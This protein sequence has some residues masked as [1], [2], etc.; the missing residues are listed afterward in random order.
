MS[1]E[2]LN[3]KP[4][5]LWKHFH[6]LTQIP[7]PTGLMEEVTKFVI[8]FGKSLGLDVKQDEIGNVLITK[9]A[10]VGLEKVPVVIL[11]SHLDMVPQKNSDVKHDFTKDPI[12]TQIEGNKV[13]ARSTTLGADNGIGA[14]AM[15][16]V[17]EDK[18][19]KHGKIEALF[20][21][22]EEVGM[23]GAIGLQPGFL[24]GDI[25]LN[26]DTE[27]IG[28]LC[29]GCA[30]GADV[31]ADWHFKDVEV[32]EGDFAYKVVLKGLRGGHSG[33]E[34]HLGRANANKL[35]FYFLKEAVSNYE[36]RLS[37][38]DGG[39]LRN[40]IPRESYAVIT[41][42]E[43]DAKDFLELV[44]EY[45]EI[46]K[47]EYKA[48]EPN[49]SF[50]AEKTDLPT[51]LIPEEIQDSLINAVVGCQNGVIG[52]LTEFEGIVETSTNLASVKSAPGHIAAKMLARSSS[53][54]RKDEICSSLE[55]VFALAGA[56]VSIENP[57]PGWQPNAKSDTLNMMSA[58]YEEMYNEKAHVVVVH[59]GLECGIILSSTPGL[60][61]VSFGPTILNAHSPDEFVEIDTVT[62]FYDYL[63]KT[64]ERV[65]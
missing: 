30:G 22:D 25:L 48:V 57:Y 17:L 1:K 55:S 34:I 41:L 3:L 24:S 19:L 45:E 10:T 53:E 8:N 42:P 50:K 56:K 28:E 27:E 2:I 52:M 26:L 23:V 5:Q 31:N 51:T 47:E 21:I 35:M 14:A 64:L 43:D 18:T 6:D 13:K 59:A 54:T 15:M 32:P 46:F 20:T 11:Q 63:V 38:V 58:L 4:Q 37:V 36:V 44:A 29:V 12:E 49:L 60:D 40:A 61:I 39:S 16:A 9:P 62:K 33:T 65:K 7:R